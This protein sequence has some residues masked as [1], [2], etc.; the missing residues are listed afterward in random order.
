MLGGQPAGGTA[1]GRRSRALSN[2]SLMDSC[3]IAGC[4]T[5]VFHPTGITV[6]FLARMQIHFLVSKSRVDQRTLSNNGEHARRIA[7]SGII[8]LLLVQTSYPQLAVPV[9]LI[10]TAVLRP[11]MVRKSFV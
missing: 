6:S 10:L 8:G 11:G 5:F 9:H 2:S 1:L 3:A 7:P 4:C